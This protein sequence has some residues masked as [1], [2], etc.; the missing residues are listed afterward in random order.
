MAGPGRVVQQR[1]LVRHRKRIVVTPEIRRLAPVGLDGGEGVLAGGGREGVDLVD[2]L[3][4]PGVARSRPH[5]SGQDRW[6]RLEEM[7]EPLARGSGGNSPVGPRL[8]NP[9]RQLCLPAAAD[10]SE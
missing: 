4:V 3:P 2:L 9:L 6:V 7:I 8:A 5:H 1:D 10:A